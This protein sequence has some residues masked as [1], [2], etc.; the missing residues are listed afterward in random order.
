MPPKHAP[1]PAVAATDTRTPLQRA[2]DEAKA[3]KTVGGWPI[4]EFHGLPG[5]FIRDMKTGKREP[6]D[7]EARDAVDNL[8][9]LQAESAK[10]EAQPR[11]GAGATETPQPTADGQ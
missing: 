2:L 4:D 5:T 7:D 11:D 9:R 3:V 10:Q 6:A 8:R 1:Q